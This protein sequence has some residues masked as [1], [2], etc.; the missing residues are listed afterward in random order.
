LFAWLLRVVARTR[1]CCPENLRSS[2]ELCDVLDRE[3]MRADRNGSVLSMLTITLA[4]EPAPEYDASLE[5]ELKA[6]ACVLQERLRTTDESGLLSAR[7]VGVVL[8]DTPAVG[9]SKVADDLTS[10][11]AARGLCITCSLY[12]YPHDD[13]SPRDAGLDDAADTG[14]VAGGRTSQ[15][16]HAQPLQPLLAQPLPAWKRAAD[17]VGASLAIVFLLP[18]MT[19][20][21]VAVK[22]S[23]PGPILFKQ[24]RGGRGGQPFVMYKYRSM[25]ADAD[26]RKRELLPLSE[27]DGPAFK[28]RDDPRVTRLGRFLR[29]T[30]L[31][32]LPQLFNVLKGEM[33]LVGPRP[34]PLEE[35]RK[36]VG[37]HGRRHDVTPGLTCLWQVEGRSAVS[38]VEWM[39]MDVNY[40]Q[41]RT[42]R[43]DL[44]ILARTVPAVLARRGAQ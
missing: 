3:R 14:V 29:A 1:G 9:A 8:P 10:I 5:H 26:A 32:E 16:A 11:C 2:E 17:V 38:F 21:A 36:C 39:R 24:Q 28:M 15:S 20:I 6:L 23:S 18:V 41:S 27:Q 30:S 34:L 22:W 7:Q 37:W 44:V 13:F 33:S 4:I 19:V 12:I 25:V 42:P 40:I 35:S 31:D 43:R